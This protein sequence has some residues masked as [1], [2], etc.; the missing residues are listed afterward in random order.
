MKRD[1]RLFLED[2]LECIDKI[3]EY[4]KGADKKAPFTE[5]WLE[6]AVLHRLEIIGEAAKHVPEDFRKKYPKIEWKKI[7][8]LRD[9][10]IHGYFGV[11]LERVWLVV[12]DDLPELKAKI[13]KIL[14]D[15]EKEAKS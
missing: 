4:M 10:L 8:G 12:Q 1:V 6:D 14:K 13:L 3:E 9:R 11:S 5:S 2:I 7:S 15:I